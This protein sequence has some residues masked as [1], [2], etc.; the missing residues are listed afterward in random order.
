[1][2][3]APMAIVSLIVLIKNKRVKKEGLLWVIIPACLVSLGGSF[4]AAKIDGK[5]LGRFFGGFLLVL[6]V[7]QFFSREIEQYLDK[8]RA[9]TATKCT[10]T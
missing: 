4:A 7:S 10:K 1:M 9:K 8:K 6:S 5:I 3:F 2:A